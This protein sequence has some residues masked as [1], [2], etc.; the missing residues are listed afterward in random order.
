[1]SNRPKENKNEVKS[2]DKYVKG[3][4]NKAAVISSKV[5]QR[6]C[7]ILYPPLT[8]S[9]G[10]DQ[11]TL[12]QW[13]EGIS[14]HCKRTKGLVKFAPMIMSEDHKP[15]LT[16]TLQFI[17][18]RP[19]EPKKPKRRAFDTEDNYNDAVEDYDDNI[20]DFKAD[21]S[22]WDIVKSAVVEDNKKYDA[23]KIEFEAGLATFCEVIVSHLSYQSENDVCSKGNFSRQ[24]LLVYKDAEKLLNLITVTHYAASTGIKINDKYKALVNV[25][26]GVI[27][28]PGEPLNTYAERL[29]QSEK[30]YVQ[31]SDNEVPGEEEMMTHVLIK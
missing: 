28:K 27:Q 26:T 11:A 7:S 25:L 24:E 22:Q 9:Q 17:P 13:K 3:N 5:I 6:G 18:I 14:Q 10:K 23:E 1:M 2:N 29:D 31:L 20:V 15:I 16:R 30:I 12:L 21:I 19:L 4:E 8:R